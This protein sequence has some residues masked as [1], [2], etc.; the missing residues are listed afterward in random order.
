[1]DCPRCKTLNEERAQ[2]CKNCGMKLSITGL[3]AI[4][5]TPSSLEKTDVYWLLGYTGWH[6]L[7]Y[8]I[9]AVI[10]KLLSKVFREM[11]ELYSIVYWIISGIDVLF[12]VALILLLKNYTGKICFGVFLL[13]RIALLFIYKA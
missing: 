13:A 11:I 2:Y 4:A 12:I 3:G 10:F 9:N 7:S 6:F 8:L 1:M 5:V